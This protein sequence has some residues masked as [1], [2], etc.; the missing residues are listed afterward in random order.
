MFE[1]FEADEDDA[2]C[3]KF[4]AA[5]GS[6]AVQ[7]LVCFKRT[8]NVSAFGNAVCDEVPAEGMERIAVVA[9]PDA[10]PESGP[11]SD[12]TV[13]AWYAY[14]VIAGQYKKRANTVCD[15]DPSW[16]QDG[17][18]TTW[19]FM[20]NIPGCEGYDDITERLEAR[21]ALNDVMWPWVLIP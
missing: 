15:C 4:D 10:T 12:A 11:S 13:Y 18:D 6:V 1:S 9:V 8:I 3:I 16:Y 14:H 7:A 21:G 17:E 2:E 20:G 5:T 19:C